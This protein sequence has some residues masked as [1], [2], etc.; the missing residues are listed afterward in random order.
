MAAGDTLSV[1][2]HGLIVTGGGGVCDYPD[3][4]DV[5]LGV[6]YGDGLLTGTYGHE[7]DGDAARLVRFGDAVVAA[8]EDGWD[9]ETAALTT[10]ARRWVSRETDNDLR[11]LS[12]RK[13]WVFPNG[14]GDESLTRAQDHGEYRT[15]IDVVRRWEA[16]GEFTD[17]WVDGEVKF[18]QDE[19]WDKLSD[20]RAAAILAGYYPNSGEVTAVVDEGMLIQNKVFWCRVDLAFKAFQ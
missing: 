2:S 7:P 4:S 13:V 6:V 14:Y 12:G 18:V 16:A 8:I 17:A 20:P 10:V 15:T 11:T 1:L 3:E 9:A 19:I 5:R